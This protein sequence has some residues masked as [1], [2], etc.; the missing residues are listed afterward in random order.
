MSYFAL[1]RCLTTETQD[2]PGKPREASVAKLFLLLVVPMSLLPP[3]MYVYAQISAPGAILPRLEPAISLNE[4]LLVGTA[5]FLAELLT[6]ALMAMFIQQL[7]D[8]VSVQPSYANAYALAATAPIPLW[9]ATLG[10][11]LPNLWVNVAF[12]SIAWL[13]SVGLIRRGVQTLYMPYDDSK[14]HKLANT[15]AFIGVASWLSLLLFLVLLLSMMLG[16]R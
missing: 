12:M 4:A 13:F 9:L 2:I 6:V 15:L 16:W 14:T 7:G 5:F 3:L 1:P 8:K 10:L 11:A